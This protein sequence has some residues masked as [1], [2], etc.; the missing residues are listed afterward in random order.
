MANDLV[1]RSAASDADRT[2]AEA[3]ASLVRQ[4]AGGRRTG[5]SI[6]QRSAELKRQHVV[7]KAVLMASAVAAIL[8][9]AIGAGI[10]INGIGFTGVM[11]TAL[12]VIMALVVF[13]QFP[14]LKVPELGAIN[15][16]SVRS[17]VANTEMWLENQR[18]ALPAPAIDVVERLGVQLD[19][20]GLQLEGLDESQPGLG[21]VRKLVGEH[22][23]ELVANYTAIPPH[24]R[25]QAHAGGTP[26]EQLTESLSR[27]NGEID[28]V[29]RQ[30]AEGQLDK[31]AIRTRFLDYKYGEEGGDTPAS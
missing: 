14:R 17:L 16:G 3:K 9:V 24:L 22:L 20:L 26:D 27:I 1:T 23:P 11:L 29:T 6:G 30:L 2:L 15:R 21:D 7:R 10:L 5:S 13:S 28:N 25:K 12:A 19:A 8:V 4:R 18:P 31:L